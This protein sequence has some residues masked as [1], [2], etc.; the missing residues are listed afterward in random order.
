MCVWWGVGEAEYM[1][2]GIFIKAL[3]INTQLCGSV[4]VGSEAD[5]FPSPV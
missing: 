5:V 2:R 4:E 1:S 3:F